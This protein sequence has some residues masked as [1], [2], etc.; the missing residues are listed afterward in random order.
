[1]HLVRPRPQK[2]WPSVDEAIAAAAAVRCATAL[3]PDGDCL[4]KTFEK[5]LRAFDDAVAGDE[6]LRTIIV[7]YFCNCLCKL[8]IE[9]SRILCTGSRDEL[10]VDSFSAC[11]LVCF[12]AAL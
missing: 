9:G 10:T 2:P 8:G 5:H 3:L 6:E 12:V 11:R 4:R 1:M 7:D